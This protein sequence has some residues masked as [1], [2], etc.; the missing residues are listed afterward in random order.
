MKY[1][2]LVNGALQYAPRNKG[3]VSNYNQ[4]VTAML[5]DGYLLVEETAYPKDGN[6]YSANYA[7]AEGKIVQSWTLVPIPE[8]VPPTIEQRVVTLEVVTGLT[9]AVR[10]LVLVENSGA[11]DYVRAKAKEIEDLAKELRATEETSGTETVGEAEN[12]L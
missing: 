3:S 7:E 5:A 11:S 9:R 6:N 10:E 12:L 4:D 2:K 1:A 8:P